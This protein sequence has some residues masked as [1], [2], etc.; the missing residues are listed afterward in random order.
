M[1]KN[2]KILFIQLC[3]LAIGCF[4]GEAVFGLPKWLGLVIAGLMFYLVFF[5]IQIKGAMS[6]IKDEVS[7]DGIA[8]AR[9]CGV[10][11]GEAVFGLP[12]WLGLVI[13]GLMFYL[14][15]FIIQ[16]KGA[17]SNIKDE[18][19]SDGIAGARICGVF[20]S[21]ILLAFILGIY[22]YQAANIA[23]TIAGVVLLIL[24][25]RKIKGFFF[26]NRWENNFWL[27]YFGIAFIICG[28]FSVFA[29]L[30][31]APC[32]ELCGVYRAIGIIVWI[33]VILWTLPP[34]TWLA[35]FATNN[36]K[37]YEDNYD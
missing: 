20:I 34:D 8:G 10:F 11:I 30:D 36:Y 31:I 15:F 18:V 5:I 33:L 27:V 3:V 17:M 6:N 35:R 29:C 7:S 23:M 12:K 28:V 26:E 4:I 14:V 25:R 19:S 2:L 24:Q 21:A 13:A 22:V 37:R 16:I 32:T 9:I 1:K